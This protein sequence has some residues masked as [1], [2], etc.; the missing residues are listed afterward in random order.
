VSKL[1][2][3][4]RLMVILGII[5]LA[6]LLTGFAIGP[7]GSKLLNVQVPA[8]VAVNKPH[9]QLPSE[10]VVTIEYK[11]GSLH[12]ALGAGERHE[13]ST[14]VEHKTSE[15]SEGDKKAEGGFRFSI[16]NTLIASWVTIIVLVLIFFFATRRV[17]I[18]PGRLQSLTEI[19]VEGMYNFIEGVAGQKN[20]RI[21]LPVVGTIF[22]YVITNAWMALIPLWGTFGIWEQVEAHGE[23]SKIL[24]PFLRAANTDINLTLSIAIVAFCFIEYL[25]L[26]KIGGLSYLDSFFQ[27]STLK[28]DFWDNLIKGKI[29]PALSG[30]AFGFINIYVG[31]LEVLS[32]FIRIV[33]FTFRLFGNMTAGEILLT[34]MTFLVPFIAAV[35]FYGL[36]TLVGFLQAMIFAGLTLVFGVMAITSHHDES[37]EHH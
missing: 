20:A 2:C 23:T 26:S 29:Q 24:I 7:L 31:L 9:I 30:I 32:H 22:L 15:K 14:S 13:A 28:K 19:I 4:T 12:T 8:T 33:S 6:L 11:D 5:V 17:S 3:S 16:T 35:P 1:G 36:E 10:P 21:F 37:A 27:F 34:V 18:I 25:G